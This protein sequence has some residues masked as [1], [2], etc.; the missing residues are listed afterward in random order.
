MASLSE[1][2]YQDRKDWN[3]E[4]IRTLFSE[5]LQARYKRV[6]D[7]SSKKNDEK[8]FQLRVNASSSDDN[9]PFAALVAPNQD[10]SGP[11]GGMSLVFFPSDAQAGK[12]ALIAMGVGT[13]GAAPDE[14][15]LGRPGHARRCDAITRLL[16]SRSADA[17]AW[18]KRDPTRVDVDLPQSVRDRLEDWQGAIKRYGKVLYAVFSP[19]PTQSRNNVILV[20]DAIDAFLDLCLTDRGLQLRTSVVPK[21]EET[22][23]EAMKAYTP[24]L[25]DESVLELLLSRKYV[26]VEGPPGTGKTSMA[27]RILANNFEESGFIV[28][29]HPG[30]TYE[31]FVGGLAPDSENAELKFVPRRGHLLDAIVSARRE[32]SRRFLMVIDE[33]NRADLAKILGEAIYLLE[34]GEPERSIR[35]QYDFP[36]IG[37]DVSLPENLYILG[38][39]NSADRSIAILDIAVRR[40]FAFVTMWPDIEVV[41]K[42]SCQQLLRAFQ[43]LQV[44]FTD[45]AT[46]SSFVL[47]PGHSYFLGNESEAKQKL[48]TGVRPLLE[49]YLS[50]GYVSGFADE[51]RAYVDTV[52][53]RE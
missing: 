38:T 43:Q 16:R 41:E 18:A 13:N 23:R 2:V 51:I 14:Y 36:E 4:K 21:A 33:I 31:G 9:I 7:I 48:D 49:E 46:D 20:E 29:F 26:V 45:F 24:K 50:Q 5:V 8:R 35:L 19:P 52:L 32:P 34:P 17:F 53:V 1:L 27:R 11:Y 22:Q 6:D 15:V 40:R 28:Q 30:T 42:K 3:E 47:M 39:M 25:D 44:I 10:L 12:P 37:H